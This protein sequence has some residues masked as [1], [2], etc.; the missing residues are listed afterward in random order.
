[1]A[2]LISDEAKDLL[3]DVKE[4]CENEVKEQCK[5]YDRTGE[6]PKEIYDKAI[7]MQLHSLE[8]PEEY[9]GPG[10]SRV[11]IA[12]LMEEMAKADAGFATTISASGLGTKP[13]L[14]AGTE[15]QK[16]KV[17]Q[18]I[19]DGG[20]GAFALTEP[21]AGSDPAAGTTTA[22]KDGDEYVLNGR[23]CFITNGGIAD[24]YCVTAL[25]D[26]SIGV[27]GMSMFLIEKGTPG[28]STGNEEDKMGIRTSN[29]CDV[30]MEDCR[31]PAANLIGAEGK[32]FGIAMKTLDQART[33]MGCVSTGIAQRAM[34]EA[35][36]YCKGRVQFGKPVIKFQAMQFKIADMAMKI[37]VS[38][39]MV[40]HSLTLMDMGLP[41]AKESAIA[42][43]YASD[44][45]M[46]VTTEAVQMFGG[47]GYSREY[48]VEK[49]MRDAK[50]FQIFE[51]SNEILHIVTANNT[52]PR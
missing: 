3:Q 13:V 4:F 8:I 51:G 40:A 44:R 31:I 12:A 41:F 11:D 23:K 26:K 5:E 48:P 42:K 27:K 46:E 6:W 32:G 7:E 24:F 21:G 49:L 17:C 50:I 29:T 22:V 35:M 30:V 20:F 28:L 10:L 38:R 19:V 14:I 25:T 2:Y 47:Y 33:W 15:E 34:E 18:I 39:Q 1:M 37:E 52:I 16:K 43:C 9:G 45:A 36:E